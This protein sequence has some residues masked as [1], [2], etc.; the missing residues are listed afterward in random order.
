MEECFK[1]QKPL[2]Q[3]SDVGSNSSISLMP[4][5]GVAN[6]DGPEPLPLSKTQVVGVEGIEGKRNIWHENEEVRKGHWRGK[7]KM[8]NIKA[9]G[10]LTSPFWLGSILH[11]HFWKIKH[12]TH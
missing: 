10:L 12:L 1:I 7:T 5:T 3:N 8:H 2:L 4:H 6:H 11:F 9:G